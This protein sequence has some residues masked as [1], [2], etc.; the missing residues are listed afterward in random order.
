M[1]K[2]ESQEQEKESKT[3]LLPQVVLPQK[4]QANSHSTEDLVHMLLF[5]PPEVP[6]SPYVPYL[7]DSVAC[8]F[9]GFSIP[10]DSYNPLPSPS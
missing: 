2:K 10:S 6:V 7:V 9:M 8:V 4:H 5:L 1:E 3:Y